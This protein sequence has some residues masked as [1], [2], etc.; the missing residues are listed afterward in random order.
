MRFRHVYMLIFSILVILA[1]IGTDPDSGFIQSLPFGAGALSYVALLLPAV[2]F[3]TL[4]HISRRGLFDYIDLSEVVKKAME[5][6]TGAGL[7]FL[8]V[9]VAMLAISVAILAAVA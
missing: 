7:V 9:C 6:S 8:G 2:L 4:I 3:V 1:L 5:N